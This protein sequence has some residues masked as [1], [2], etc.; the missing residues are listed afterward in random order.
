MPSSLELSARL[1][2]REGLSQLYA[3]SAGDSSIAEGADR[4]ISFSE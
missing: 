1:K 3:F 2:Y 4:Q